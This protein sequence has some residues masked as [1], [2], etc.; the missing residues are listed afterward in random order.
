MGRQTS[1]GAGRDGESAR[2]RRRVTPWRAKHG[3]RGVK[4]PEERLALEPDGRVRL[5]LKS[6][7]RDGTKALLLNP[8]ALVTRLCAAV[9]PP[10]FHTLRYY[11]VLSS[12]SALRRELAPQHDDDDRFRPPD[13]EGDQLEL[14]G[15]AGLGT[16]ARSTED[17]AT[18]RRHRRACVRKK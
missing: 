8:D 6:P 16:P 9:P 4:L 1:S 18:P 3:G 11:G 12:R 15:L 7:W 10:R 2:L 14:A 13:A 17:T 5:T